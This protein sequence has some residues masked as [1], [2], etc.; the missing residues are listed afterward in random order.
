MH[1]LAKAA[2]GAFR[3]R[4]LLIAE[5]LDLRAFEPTGRLA[6]DP[7][8]IAAGACGIAVLFR[9][10]AIVL[11]DVSPAEELE[12]LRQLQPLAQQPYATPEIESLDIRI[13]AERREGIEGSVLSLSDYAIERF[14]LVAD[15][16]SKST[17]LAM[18]EAR[19][20]RSFELVE[21]FAIDLERNSRSS[22]TAH[23]LLK[24]I[25]SA[26]LSEHTMV[27]RVEVVDK[28]EIIWEHPYL[29]RLY[30]RLEDEFEVRE[31]HL[32]LERKLELVARTAQTVLELLQNN[33][34][35]R[36]EWYVLLLIFLEVLLS[37]WQMLW[38]K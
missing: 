7:L 2:K 22:R 8:V 35:L 24:Q 4:A 11:F 10:G 12:I 1:P 28:P 29:E 6:I 38:H 16:L 20:R 14:Q 34:I 23:T 32:A 3:A 18:Y 31:R 15:V 17:V 33:R 21:P 9:Y 30:A 13:D 36:L 27:G 5:R 37:V 19:V 26:L 25:G